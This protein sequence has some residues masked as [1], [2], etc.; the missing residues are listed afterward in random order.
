MAAVPGESVRSS[1]LEAEHLPVLLAET[2]AGLALSAGVDCI[3]GTL[4]GAGHAAAMLSV[5]TPGGRLLG[6]DADPEA[7][8]RARSRLAEFG[9]RALI[10]QANFRDIASIA[11][12]HGFGQVSAILLDLG[13]SSGQLAS[14]SR[15]FSFQ[16]EGS[17]DM[18]FDPSTSLTAAE[19]VNEW[20]TDDLAD[21]LFRYGEEPQARRFARAIVAARPLNT[22]SELAAVISRAAATRGRRRTHPAT[23]VFQALRIAVND[24]LGALETA[25]SQLPGL[26]IHGGRFGMITFHS[27]EDRIVKQFIQREARDCICPPDFPVCRC[28]HQATLRAVTRRP[29][30]PAET[31]ISL[32]PRSR[33]AKL[34]IAERL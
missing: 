3:D 34:R 23:R 6:L 32:N 9:D 27:L 16:T 7:V 21:V 26:L 1:E 5:T 11:T 22:S 18:R 13:L 14:P 30:R 31:E 17:L 15:G 10:V 8:V 33:S 4:G 20:Q 24:E 29:I 25:L 19:I 2:I 28:G 12:A